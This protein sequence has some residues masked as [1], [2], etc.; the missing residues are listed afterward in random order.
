MSSMPAKSSPM[1]DA[2]RASN[3]TSL[4]S[5]SIDD[6]RRLRE[7]IDEYELAID[8][9]RHPDPRQLCSESPWLAE[10]LVATLRK[11]N[12]LDGMLGRFPQFLQPKHIGEFEV[13]QLLGVGSSGFVFR[14]RQSRPDREIA[15]KLLKPLLSPEEQQER[16]ERELAALSAVQYEGIVTVYHSGIHEWN[17]IRCLWIAMELLDGGDLCSFVRNQKSSETEVLRLFRH[18]CVTVR[19]AHRLGILHRD[20]KPSNILLDSKKQPKIVDFGIARIPGATSDIHQTEPGQ[21][22]HR[23]TIAWSAPELLA[24]ESDHPADVRSEIFS[25][26]VVL[27]ELLTGS[28]PYQAE[29]YSV[30]QVAVR[31][32]SNQR[33]DVNSIAPHLSADSVAILNR[34]MMSDPGARYPN[35]DDVID[36]LDRL[37]RHEPVHARR[38]FFREKLVR[39]SQRNRPT[40]AVLSVTAISAI[41]VFVATLQ[42]ASRVKQH[43]KLLEVANQELSENRDE[44]IQTTRQ[45]K[46]TLAMRERSIRSSLLSSLQHSV[47]VNSLEVQRQLNDTE[48]FPEKTRSVAWHLL[49]DQVQV[50]VDIMSAGSAEV[51]GLGYEPRTRKLFALSADGTLRIFDLS[52]SHH[53]RTAIQ[54][55]PIKLRGG[56]GLQLIP[57]TSLIMAVDTDQKFVELN[58][59]DGSPERSLTS[60]A[61]VRYTFRISPNGKWV[62]GINRNRR[63]FLLDRES[64]QTIFLN[65]K[66]QDHHAGI[67]FSSDSQILS[68]VDD[69]GQLHRWKTASGEP[70]DGP[71]DPRFSTDWE[72]NSLKIADFSASMAEGEAVALGRSNGSIH[73]IHPFLP[74]ERRKTISLGR[75]GNLRDIQMVPPFHILS[76]TDT[77]QLH[78]VYASPTDIQSSPATVPALP[79][80]SKTALAIDGGKRIVVGGVDGS[81]AIAE[82]PDRNVPVRTI[83]PFAG[84]PDRRFGPPVQV[85]NVP[86]SPVMFTGHRAGWIA[87]VNRVT[88][89]GVEAF[90]IADGPVNGLARHPSRPLIA[91]GFGGTK[92]GI[93]TFQLK[94]GD[95]LTAPGDSVI[96]DCPNAV[97]EE[98]LA[99]DVRVLRFSSDG[100]KLFVACRNGTLNVID[101]ENWTSG[102]F[103]E[104]HKGGIFGMDV[105]HDRVVTTGTDGI[106]RVWKTSDLSKAAEWKAHER[107]IRD[108]L[109]LPDGDRVATA[110]LDGEIRIWTLDGNLQN[111]LIGHS[112]GVVSLAL[113]GDQQTL[114]SGGDDGQL[115][116]WDS[117]TGDI[118]LRFTGHQDSITDLTFTPHRNQLVSAGYDDQLLLWGRDNTQNNSPAEQSLN[119]Q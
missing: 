90:R 45:L 32:A 54:P 81:I 52:V 88:G 12:S 119:N 94:E 73:I 116:F 83:T 103:I 100:T 42:S 91:V 66:L 104:A 44:L 59:S 87:A 63:V 110:S 38:I 93:R 115:V 23:G 46:S 71:E 86:D 74:I 70:L 17:G 49:Q 5:L 118:Q 98:E 33:L 68:L 31:I 19:A 28:H 10:H 25:L 40:V 85:L 11:L 51:G 53:A 2:G 39:W 21:P 48:I 67:W 4:P 95:R 64:D 101:C 15:V 24:R 75:T 113:S 1:D 56:P 55:S 84:I 13:V 97:F 102:A 79:G 107:R 96:R 78:H 65:L 89:R 114:V 27:F 109:V 108:V 76:I 99:T 47:Y 58:I 8:S 72:V 105:H 69:Q 57:D 82:M 61:D 106:V 112:G 18:V 9:G 43:A 80:R 41:F 77:V 26:G 117:V 16:F 92:P 50:K 111:R 37:H 3:E 7:L 36:D 20:L 62:A 22:G 6:Q 14:C 60:V 34:M 29:H 35:L 30:P